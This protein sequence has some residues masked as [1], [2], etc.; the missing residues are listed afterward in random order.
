MEKLRFALDL[1]CNPIKDVSYL[2]VYFTLT[3]M[4]QQHYASL[5]W[6]L[7]LYRLLFAGGQAHLLYLWLHPPASPL[8]HA[9]FFDLFYLFIPKP[10]YNLFVSFILPM[11]LYF[12]HHLI[13]R[14]NTALNGLLGSVI[15]HSQTSFFLESTYKGKSV[16]RLVRRVYLLTLNTF[17]SYLAFTSKPKSCLKSFFN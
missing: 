11:L 13:A 1:V 7:L 5:Q 2:E 6:S 15:L 3:R 10:V 14:P 8:A 12:N 17:Q 16:V 9:Q 4:F